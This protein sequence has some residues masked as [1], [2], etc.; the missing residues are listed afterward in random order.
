LSGPDILKVNR[1]R[2]GECGHVWTTDKTTNEI[3]THIT[4]LTR[5]PAEKKP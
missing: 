1:Y 4:P 3:V 5:K 2:C